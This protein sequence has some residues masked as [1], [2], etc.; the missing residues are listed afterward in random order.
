[1]NI[2][3]KISE[4]AREARKNGN[5]EAANAYMIALLYIEDYLQEK[6]EREHKEQAERAENALILATTLVELYENR[7]NNAD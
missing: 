5:E 4:L 1:M 3:T 7:I 2:A 6:K